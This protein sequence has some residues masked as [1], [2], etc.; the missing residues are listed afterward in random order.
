[1]PQHRV[2]ADVIAL[3]ARDTVCARQ[4]VQDF[5]DGTGG[6]MVD[7]TCCRG[8][9]YCGDINCGRS[10]RSSSSSY[11]G[12]R[13]RGRS[14]GTKTG[15][16]SSRGCRS[17]GSGNCNSGSDCDSNNSDSA[18]AL[19]VF[20]A[21][22]L[23]F[24]AIIYLAPYF[25]PLV[26]IGIE[27]VL[28]LFFGLFELISFGIFRKKFRRV[29]IHFPGG[30]P[31]DETMVNIITDAASLGGLTR[32]YKQQY[33]TNGFWFLRTGAYLFFPSLVTTLLVLYLQPENDYLFRLPIICFVVAIIFLW[34][35]NFQ[36]NRKTKEVATSSR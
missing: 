6:A 34:F 30:H 18:G 7:E 4:E 33:G 28:A 3:A 25:I 12:G 17:S 35:G 22:V 10:T 19:I 8:Y 2:K 15:R 14:S 16:S 32:H 1:M 11:S 13:G 23:I 31:E 29:L 27:L 26:A 24:L 20:F 5:G 21:I 36:V 9:Y